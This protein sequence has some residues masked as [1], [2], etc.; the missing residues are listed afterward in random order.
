MA[1]TPG[2]LAGIGVVLI[3]LALGAGFLAGSGTDAQQVR[4]KTLRQHSEPLANAAQGLYS[5]LSVAD[6]SAGTAFLAGGLQPVELLD[7]YNQALGTASAALSTAAIGVDPSDAEAK[8]LLAQIGSQLPIYTGLVATANS[9]NRAGNPV[10][11]SYLSEASNLMQ[12]TILPEAQQLYSDQAAIVSQLEKRNSTLDWAPLA[13][14]ALTLVMLV[15]FQIRIARQSRRVFNFGLLPATLAM[16]VLLGWLLTAGLI[17]SSYSQRALTESS[18]PMGELTSARILAQQARTD[19]TMNLLQRANTSIQY[20]AFEDRLDEISRLISEVSKPG[21][22]DTTTQ[23]DGWRRSHQIMEDRL[24]SGDYPGAVAATISTD[25]ASSASHFIALD[26]DLSEQIGQLRGNGQSAVNS[27]Y[28][29]LTLLDV[30][31]GVLSVAAAL[32]IGLGLWPRLSEY[33]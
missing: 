1:S 22:G 13:L 32:L 18:Q 3:L 17:S 27:S 12:G 23:I 24:G 20:N 7:R 11:V 10:G 33:Q 8:H 21:S 31:S 28:N 26:R 14:T 25:S 9:N 4:I 15:Y 16:A 30:G 5:S 29:A 19:E 2:R 6:A